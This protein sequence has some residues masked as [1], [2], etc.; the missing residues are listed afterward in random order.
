[1]FR[2]ENK[3]RKYDMW[4]KRLFAFTIALVATLT[5]I[6]TVCY[7]EG[8]VA[9]SQVYVREQYIDVFVTG[10]LNPDGL[11]VKV[12][13]QTAT[14]TGSCS[15][16]DGDIT[17][18]TT[19][20]VDISTS[21]PSVTRK[22][23]K[24]YIDYLI[25]NIA[26]NEQLK[27]VTF[28]E[29]LTALQDF[30]SD[31]YDLANAAGKIEFN[32]Q[33]S[34]IYDA[35]YNTMPNVST[36]DGKPCYYR[37]IVITDGIDDT[38]TGVT[39]EELYLK[40]QTNVYPVDVVAVSKTKQAEP[41]KE[42][43][44]LTRMSGGRYT[45]IYQDSDVSLVH[46]NLAVSNIYWM[47]AEVPSSLLDGS[48]R[49][50]NISDGNNSIQFDVKVSIFDMPVVETPTPTEQATEPPAV[51]ATLEISQEVLPTTPPAE[52]KNESTNSVMTIFG[53]YT[54]VVFICAGVLF[55]ILIAVVIAVVIIR[56]KRK[57]QGSS[58]GSEAQGSP[59]NEIY[60]EKTE[61][62]SD[63]NMA[64]AQFTIKISNPNNSSMN[65]TIPVNNEILVGRAEYAKIRL[66]DTSVS[67]EQC[68]IVIQG[69]GLT[70]VHLSKTNKTFL[71]G[72]NV[73]VSSPLQSG[74]NFKFG[75]VILHIDYIQ[76]L[77]TPPQREPEQASR[78]GNTES[79]F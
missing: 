30:T 55:I 61:Y 67:R 72:T 53:D 68:K 34:K 27:I 62:I 18:R 9:L 14:V 54:L 50:V 32:G 4:A 15:V 75:R 51:T 19:V 2:K 44:A 41:E 65:W 77:G 69:A 20:L 25:E 21:M 71:N 10:T 59:K 13:N 78:G 16:S 42:L 38:A 45:N 35:I 60:N 7:A 49:Q 57:Q 3:E 31:R 5:N 17:I 11:N 26:K 58:Y 22:N 63:E 56:G 29:Q 52:E 73:A 8:E 70:V 48:I 12:S 79:I 40:F 74:D 66:D 47:R 1:M 6:L 33:Q 37:T 24:N 64:G 46:S 23:V 36:L 43:S 28:G 39:K 76:S